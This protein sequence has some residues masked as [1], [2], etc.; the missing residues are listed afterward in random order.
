MGK[1]IHTPK[2][3]ADPIYGIIDVR[4]ILP[5]IETEEFQALGDK[6]QLGMSYLVFPSATH[7]RRAHS[8]GAYHA[9]R[10]LADRWLNLGLISEEEAD[11]LA[12]YAL[13]HDI[14]HPA[15]SHVTEDLCETENTENLDMSTN[16][17]LSLAIIKNLK[18]AIENC[19]INFEL[20]EEIA[21]HKNPLYLAVSDKNLGMEKLDYLER[22]GF[23]TILSRLSGVD[24]LREH[25]YFLDGKLAIDEKVIDNAIEAQN[26]YLKMYKNVY[27]RKVSVIAQRMFHKMVYH[28]ILAGELKASEL[29]QMTDSE[30]L[31]LMRFSKDKTVITLYALF[32]SR[33]L[34]KEAV[35]MRPEG[36]VHAETKAGKTIAVFGVDD[37]TMRAFVQSPSLQLKNPA[38]L[39]K[40]E[41]KIGEIA[42]IPTEF[43][44]VV[45]LVSFT[46][47]VSQ[48]IWIY[49][50]KGLA[51]LK[52]RYPAH[53][54]EMEEVGK[55]YLAFRICTLE[56]YRK[57]LSTPA[58]AKQI[59]DL[60]V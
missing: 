28:L 24:Y 4:P 11:A 34:F 49:T 32:K 48:D 52:E 54:K 2:V 50:E 10:K 43:I 46:K 29:Q 8:L 35:V 13:Y 20:L 55:S 53:F 44:L 60:V 27:L 14:G 38:E 3:I 12:G 26:F 5:M 25:I 15:F 18:N 42:G 57:Q 23:H 47:F 30:L 1:K 31:G 45:P 56:K 58:L 37:K 21:K 51:S 17:L 39:E 9:T 33:Q 19:G 59:S 22:D 41:G 6:R 36:F 16:S 7:T 40:L